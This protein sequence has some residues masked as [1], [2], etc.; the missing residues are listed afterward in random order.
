MAKNVNK[1]KWRRLTTRIRSGKF[2]PIIS[3]RIFFPNEQKLITAWAD[4]IEYPY[5]EQHALNLASVAQY[6]SVSEEDELAAKEDFLLFSKEQLLDHEQTKANGK[7]D[8]F[9]TLA[10]ELEEISLSETA[11]RLNYPQ[12][13]NEFENPLV[14]L[15]SLPLPIYIT[16]SYYD[17][18]EQALRKAGKKPRTEICYWKDQFNDI[19][20]VF[21]EDPDYQPSEEEPLVYHFH[22]I[23]GYPSSLVLT[24]DD[25][26]DFLVQVS[27][28]R[29]TVP[30]RV[31]QA[32]VDSSLLLLGYLLDDW[33]FKVMYRGLINPARAS[34]RILN[35]AIQ[36]SPEDEAKY[37]ENSEEVQDYL[38]QYFEKDGFS[39]YWGTP[40][41]FTQ[42]LWQEWAD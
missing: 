20:S 7:A 8:F 14:I 37:G 31:R 4:E 32:L 25:Y 3:N 28:F 13:E 40:Q 5:P 15:A 19:P 18:I 26:L 34:L 33:D 29:D 23:D 22:G 41:A 24:E 30:A 39:I 38:E 36:I 17:L 1:I 27:M 16:T 21:E 9:E 35:L 2:V 10:D 11:A 42:E 12:F 6:H